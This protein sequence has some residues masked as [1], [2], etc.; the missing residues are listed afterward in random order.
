MANE[1]GLIETIQDCN[2]LFFY[3]TNLS[4]EAWRDP[5]NL[6]AV[7]ERIMDYAKQGEESTQAVLDMVKKVQAQR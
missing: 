6:Q 2:T 7:C 5:K 1:K 3:I 4:R